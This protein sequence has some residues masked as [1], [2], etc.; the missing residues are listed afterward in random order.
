MGLDVADFAGLGWPARWREVTE[1]GLITKFPFTGRPEWHSLENYLYGLE[2]EHM[3]AD[4]QALSL[5]RT[6]SSSCT[7]IVYWPLNKGAPLFEFG[8]VDYDGRPLMNF[9]VVRRLFA[10]VALGL[11]RDV[12]DVRVVASNLS[13][14]SIEASVRLV[15]ATSD[16]RVEV[17]LEQD[18]SVPPGGIARLADL[19]GYYRQVVDRTKELV[20]AELVVDGAVLVAESL[21]FCPTYEFQVRDLEIDVDAKRLDDVTWEITVISTRTVKLLQIEGPGR[22]L[23]SD[24]YFTLLAGSA[25]T[26]V[27]RLSEPYDGTDLSLV[28]SG[29]GSRTSVTC[30]LP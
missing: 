1:L 14:H 17:L 16:G 11:Y 30:P 21:F 13:A 23:F 18:V 24:N 8:C 2:V 15:S 12:D 28:I 25:R 6:R 4:H 22:W 19:P 3:E 27:A 20:H 26:V 7:G 9:Y 29:M 10:D 5:L